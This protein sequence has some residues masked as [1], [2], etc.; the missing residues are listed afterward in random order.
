MP[1]IRLSALLEEWGVEQHEPEDL[2]DLGS[3]V[4]CPTC[5]RPTVALIRIAIIS[6]EPAVDE[7][8]IEVLTSMGAVIPMKHIRTIEGVCTGCARRYAHAHPDDPVN[9]E[10]LRS[11]RAED[12]L[13]E[14]SFTERPDDDTGAFSAPDMPKD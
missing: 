12:S 13:Y 2:S 7:A 4:K 5:R 11:F 3:I 8:G 14:Q 1:L 6:E 9:I 10:V